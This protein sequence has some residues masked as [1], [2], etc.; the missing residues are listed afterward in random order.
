MNKSE[1]IDSYSRLMET[2]INSRRVY[3]I[4]VS[5]GADIHLFHNKYHTTKACLDLIKI[6]VDKG[7]DIECVTDNLKMARGLVS[8][9]VTYVGE[10][11]DY[12]GAG[13][14]INGVRPKR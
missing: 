2:L 12:Y 9:L 4:L 14:V 6:K 5:N 13:E 11:V 1:V 10:R 3:E 7:N 8:D